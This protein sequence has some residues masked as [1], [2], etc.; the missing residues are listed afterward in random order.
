MHAK[1]KIYHSLCYT[2]H[3]SLMFLVRIIRKEAQEEVANY[4]SGSNHLKQFIQVI[5][6]T[7]GGHNLG[8]VC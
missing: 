5:F 6:S 7:F 8:K 2:D 1:D 3:T 4:T